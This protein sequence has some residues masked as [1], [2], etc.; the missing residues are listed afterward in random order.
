MITAIL[1]GTEEVHPTGLRPIELP[2]NFP[3]PFRL[4]AEKKFLTST[5][6]KAR[7]TATSRE[8]PRQ[9][10]LARAPADTVVEIGMPRS[11]PQHP[12][13]IESRFP[14]PISPCEDVRLSTA[15]TL[16]PNFGN[17]VMAAE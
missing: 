15:I 6:A 2:T 16:V 3:Y 4:A 11:K 7:T 13:R 9:F 1:V 5:P 17:K 12:A 8:A 14:Q 10:P